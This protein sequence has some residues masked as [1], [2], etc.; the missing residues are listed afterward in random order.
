M[1]Q[2]TS[3][4]KESSWECVANMD[5]SSVS[6][7][8]TWAIILQAGASAWFFLHQ[9]IIPLVHKAAI[10]INCIKVRKSFT[11]IWEF[12]AFFSLWD[13]WHIIE[14]IDGIKVCRQNNRL[15]ARM[16]SLKH[17]EFQKWL[18]FFFTWTAAITAQLLFTQSQ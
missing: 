3:Q 2:K 18:L 12:Y 9:P 10:K 4:L 11:F 17:P 14:R 16:S 6:F 8:K 1:K 7:C 13:Q 5:L 15:S